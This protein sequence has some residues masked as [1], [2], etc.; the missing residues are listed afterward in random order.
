MGRTDDD[1]L[2]NNEEYAALRDLADLLRIASHI[3]AHG[4]ECE[5]ERARCRVRGYIREINAMVAS[6]EAVS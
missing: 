5:A 6:P 3:A 2:M 4:D 1:N